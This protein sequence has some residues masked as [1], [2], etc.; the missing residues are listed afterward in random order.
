MRLRLTVIEPSA[1]RTTA[2]CVD[3]HWGA[4][5]ADLLRALRATGS[6]A[7]DVEPGC[8]VDGVEVPL[9]ATLGMPPLLDGT[10]LVVRAP[11]PGGRADPG[12][13]ATPGLLRLHAI[14]GPDTGIVHDL[15]PGRHALGRSAVAAIPV[16]DPSLSRLHAELLVSGRSVTVRDLDSTNGTWVDGIPVGVEPRPLEIGATLRTG[17]S[18]WRLRTPSGVSAATRPDQRGHLLVSRSPTISDADP[19]EAIAFPEPPTDRPGQRLPLLASVLPLVLAGVLAIVLQSPTML[20]FG[21]MGPVLMLATWLSDRRH[22]RRSS[23]TEQRAYAAATIAAEA[24]LTKALAEERHRR[25]GAD[26]DPAEL[27]CLARGPLAGLWDR[28]GRP[29]RARVGVGTVPARQPV[30]GRSEPAAVAEV[31]VVL[32]LP[33]GAATGIVGPRPEALRLARWLVGQLAL[34]YSPADLVIVASAAPGHRA[35]SWVHDLPH[36]L[37]GDPGRCRGRRALVILDEG[38]APPADGEHLH[39][40]AV[41]EDESGLP[42][43]CT[44]VIDVSRAASVR[45]PAWRVA[46]LSPDGVPAAWAIQVARRLGPLR[47]A[48]EPSS[49]AAGV[50]SRVTLLDELDLPMRDGIPD[51][52]RHWQARP[53]TTSFPAGSS[54]PGRV[55]LDLVRDG[56]H[57]LVGGTTGSGKS[58]LLISLVAA[59][60]AG[61]RPD[62]LSFVLVDYK[63]G[64]AFGACRELPHVLGMV[65]D[66]DHQLTGRALAS[67]DAE[68]KR[69]ERILAERDVADLAAYQRVCRPGDPTVGRLVIVVDEFRS[70]AE[71]LPEFVAGLVRIASLGRSLGVHLVVATQRPG[72]VVTSDMRANLGLR[73]ALRVRDVIDSLDVVESPAAAAIRSDT[74]GRAIVTSAATAAV[75]VQTPLATGPARSADDPPVRLASLDGVPVP[76]LPC[77]GGRPSELDLIVG[78]ANHAV[79]TLGIALPPSPWLPPL[80]GDLAVADLAAGVGSPV[81]LGR[82]DL[83][84]LQRQDDWCWDPLRE[85]HLAV[86]GAPRTGRS[87]ALVTVASQLAARFDPTQLHL[88]AVHPGSLPAVNLLPHTGAS[89]PSAD[90]PRLARLLALLESPPSA[91]LRVLLV[92]NWERVCEDLDRARAGALR[93][94]L[95]ALLRL[96]PAERLAVALTGGRAALS[97]SLAQL[98][99]RRVLLLPADPVDLAIA[100][101]SPADVP[102]GA[103]PGRAVDLADGA[104]VQLAAPVREPTAAR[105]A[106][107]LAE[108]ARRHPGLSMGVQQWPPTVPELPAT[109]ARTDLA[110]SATPIP[111]GT[112]GEHALGFDPESGQRSLT[113]LGTRGSGR[114]TTLRTIAGALVE[115]GRPVAWISA[116]GTGPSVGLPEDVARFGPCDAEGLIA[117]RRAHPDLAVL[118]DDAERATDTPIEPV[119]RE[120]LRLVDTDRGLIA[121]ASTR[122]DVARTPRSLP[123]QVAAA[124]VGI[125]LGRVPPGE[126]A[127]LGVRGTLCS[128]ELPGRGH[129][130]ANGRATP[131]QVAVS[132]P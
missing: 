105:I 35:W 37:G 120:I 3:A 73:I 17:D 129:L 80:P 124:G 104:E 15:L 121:I 60:A 57:A 26:P 11:T 93:E 16:G 14:A 29:L 38:H 94:G 90:L 65:T 58:E 112:N 82:R 122:H 132:S 86:L 131:I 8:R 47:D 115:G 81:P 128:D 4:T 40:L 59:L 20:L 36:A 76:E 67:L 54:A 102:V 32:D 113:V 119:L 21:L 9:T 74:P 19:H 34:R 123:S 95:T 24:R 109:V 53:R 116:S 69:R 87:T 5:L 30:A 23:R 62:E 83:P 33:P 55:V 78:A 108:L 49:D 96:G 56:P 10:Q 63:G 118:V 51:L 72:G 28:T 85:G 18:I 6:R 66:L 98:V 43:A 88:Y 1:S 114:S 127:V 75:E 41:A 61:N 110:P 130:I 44:Q 22:G 71:E 42:S 46:D 7:L 27:G 99:P 91:A 100:G 126:E 64:A 31:P 125:L 12:S 45:T 68:L 92:D 111:V 79:A 101:L 13:R 77:P 84:R 103:P 117:L 107:Y 25:L 39:V 106:A 52:V 2:V 50:P 97:G 70:L 89:V 48:A